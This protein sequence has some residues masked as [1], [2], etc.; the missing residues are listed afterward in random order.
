MLLPII[1]CNLFIFPFLGTLLLVGLPMLFLA[2]RA[3]V[4]LSFAVAACAELS[5]M[6][7]PHSAMSARANSL[8]AR[9]VV[10]LAPGPLA[11]D[12]S[13][14]WKP[15]CELVDHWQPRILDISVHV[16]ERR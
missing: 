12:Y 15:G 3:A 6:R 2:R 11:L 5:G 14:K 7:L 16:N 4:A 10:G 8:L 1:V 9:S 13:G